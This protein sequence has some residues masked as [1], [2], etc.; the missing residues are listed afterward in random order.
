MADKQKYSER[1]IFG[2]DSKFVSFPLLLVKCGSKCTFFRWTFFIWANGLKSRDSQSPHIY[3]FTFA[4]AYY[5][6]VFFHFSLRWVWLPLWNC[7]NKG[8]DWRFK[9]RNKITLTFYIL[10]MSSLLLTVRRHQITF[11]GLS[12]FHTVCRSTWIAA[13]KSVFLKRTL[14]RMNHFLISMCL[15]DFFFFILYVDDENGIK[16]KIQK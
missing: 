8:F 3:I 1:F 2:S 6:Y 10:Y 16:G 5:V 15:L 9:K 12:Q 7:G 11:N 4:W 13:N 14:R